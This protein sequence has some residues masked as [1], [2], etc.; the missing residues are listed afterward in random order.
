MANQYAET[1]VR[2]IDAE[3]MILSESN[4]TLPNL[5][6]NAGM[7]IFT[8]GSAPTADTFKTVVP[9]GPYNKETFGA[10]IETLPTEPNGPTLLQN[11][12][13][14]LD[15]IIRDLKGKTA[16]LLFT[17]GT[18]SNDSKKTKPLLLAKQLVEKYDT[19][20]YAVS[21]ATG[22]TEK[23]M[24]KAMTEL[25]ECSMVI[26]FNKLLGHPGYVTGALYKISM[27]SAATGIFFDFDKSELK[28]E[29]KG[30]LKT[31]GKFLEAKP[32]TRVILAGYTDNTGKEGYNME[33]S[34]KRAETVRDY[35][36]AN[37]KIDPNRVSLHWYGK[38]DPIAGNDSDEG[39]ALNRRVTIIV[40]K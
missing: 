28:D 18:F 14:K 6:W 8:P 19:C 38:N 5:D 11:G 35:L 31:L 40:T 10:A 24:V 34:K 20:I 23:E 2:E 17:D 22:Q 25:N 27:K 39:R 4:K 32:E 9:M 26:P 3:K 36:M 15:P 1:T 33:L 37:A 21:S 7:Y 16:V 30:Q 29:Q 13:E 12:L